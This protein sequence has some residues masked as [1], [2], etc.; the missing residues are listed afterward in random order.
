MLGQT[1]EGENGQSEVTEVEGEGLS[2]ESGEGTGEA[3]QE[4]ENAGEGKS[5]VEKEEVNEL[6]LP[7]TAA[8]EDETERETWPKGF[9]ERLNREKEKLARERAEKVALQEK[10]SSNLTPEQQQHQANQQQQVEQQFGLKPP[11]RDQFNSDFEFFDAA[12]EYKHTIARAVEQQEG[13]KKAQAKFQT[14]LQSTVS[15]GK[16]KYKDFIEKTQPL[17][18]PDFPP[19][20]AMAEA[21]LDSDHKSDMFYFLGMHVDE[22]KRIANL[23]PVQAVKEIARLEA[24]FIAQK[25]S[26]ISKAPAPLSP[27]QGGG[28]GDGTVKGPPKSDNA[29]DFRRWYEDRHGRI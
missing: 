18:S 20:R 4:S 2:I 26:N 3:T 11:E 14:N 9:K 22:A 24:R 21:I 17:F 1:G 12:L 15:D 6:P 16:E 8:E 23:N 7:E 29:D 10:L 28:G 13:M 19:N 27:T 5:P 25:R